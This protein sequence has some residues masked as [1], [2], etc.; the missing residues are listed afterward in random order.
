MS[1]AIA[2]FLTARAAFPSISWKAAGEHHHGFRTH[3]GIITLA[4]LFSATFAKAVTGR[5]IKR[6]EKQIAARNQEKAKVLSELKV[7]QAR[8]TVLAQNITT[9]EKKKK[10]LVK[11]IS[12]MSEDLE[13]LEGEAKNRQKLNTSMREKLIRPTRASGRD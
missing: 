10:R 4:T 1:E 13:I 8:G 11:K 6:I 9:M 2:A 5:L 7:A 12:K 3:F